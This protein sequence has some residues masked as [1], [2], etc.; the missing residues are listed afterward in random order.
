RV[1]GPDEI[2]ATHLE[3]LGWED[4]VGATVYQ[5]R[6]KYEEFP[7]VP[8]RWTDFFRQLGVDVEEK[9]GDEVTGTLYLMPLDGERRFVRSDRQ[10]LYDAITKYAENMGPVKKTKSAIVHSKPESPPRRGNSFF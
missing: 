7:N 10:R 1:T 5:P 6:L 2:D 3:E 9:E 8:S 4:E